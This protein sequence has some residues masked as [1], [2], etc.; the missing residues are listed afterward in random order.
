[1]QEE[2][3]PDNCCGAYCSEVCT[4][5]GGKAKEV[6][7]R[8]EDSDIETDIVEEGEVSTSKQKG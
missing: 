5:C 7:T 6:S 1:M 4:C 3:G 2:Y 8:K